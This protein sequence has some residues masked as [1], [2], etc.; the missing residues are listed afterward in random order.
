[1]SVDLLLLPGLLCDQTL[2]S[3][4][5]KALDGLARIQIA[6]HTKDDNFSAM[7]QRALANAPQSFALA[8]LS[9]GGY[10]ALEIMR[11]APNRVQKLALLDTSPHADATEQSERRLAFIR[12]SEQGEFR[13]VTKRLLPLLIHKDRLADQ[14]LCDAIY[15]MAENIGKDA[16]IRQ[17]LAIMSRPD[18]TP[19]LKR[20]QQQTLVLCGRQDALTPL[21]LHQEMA[22]AIPSAKLSVIEECGHLSTMER[23]EAVNAALKEWLL[24]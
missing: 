21:H 16:F 13:G 10:L 9:M 11:Q 14:K 17:Q 1:M 6:D 4:Q 7:A 3:A 2:W 22:L 5:V 24:A 12:M 18:S 20:I 19:D 8:G 23:P 15:K